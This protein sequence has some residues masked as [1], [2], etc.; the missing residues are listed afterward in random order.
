MYTVGHSN[1]S[2][3]S[4][5][6][7][8]HAHAITHLCDVRAVPRSTYSPQFNRDALHAACSAAG[9]AYE[10]HG[11]ALGGKFVKGGVEGRLASAEGR[12]ALAGLAA[13]A[14]TH[15]G[16]G[17]NGSTRIALMCS[18]ARWCE[19]HRAT[20]A[21]ELVA[22]HGCRVL[23]ITPGAHVERHPVT[24]TEQMQRAAAAR[25][26]LEREWTRLTKHRLPALAAAHGAW[27]L[28]EDHCFMRVALDQAYGGC[29]Y[30]HLDRSRGAAIA[31]VATADLE[32]AVAAARRMEAEGVEAVRELNDASVQW[33][34]QGVVVKR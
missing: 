12:D 18:E 15:V 21:R 31:Q 2:V 28:T 19:C 20:L 26:A 13:R 33:R 14:D 34:A 17:G 23:H 4:L 6:G 9:V 29:W 1:Q 10:W 22:K 7:L 24:L 16:V 32:K 30:A 25:A 3:E 5:F 11:G 8:L 27:P